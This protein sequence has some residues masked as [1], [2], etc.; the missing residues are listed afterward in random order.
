[1]IICLGILLP[2]SGQ[3]PD[4]SYNPY[5]NAGT[6]SPSPLYPTQVNGTGI[7]SFNF[8]NS[9]SDALDVYPDQQITLTITLSYGEPNAADPLNALSGDAV[10]YFD[11]TYNAGTYTAIQNAQIAAGYAGTVEIDYSVTQNSASPG[12]NGFN[13]NITPAPYQTGSNSL[14][15]DAVS[16]YT[17]TEISDHG[18]APESYGDAEHIIN[19]SLYFGSEIDGE[20]A[21]PYSEAADG[22]DT[23]NLDDEDG[24]VFPDMMRRGETVEISVLTV[25][26]GYLNAWF[27]WNGDG[28]FNDSGELVEENLQKLS[29]TGAIT[30]IIP[31][32]AIISSATYARFRISPN[33][34][35]FPT[36]TINGGEVEDYQ[37]SILC[38]IPEPVLDADKT[39]VCS[40][41]T[42]TFQASGGVNYQFRIDGV[43]VQDGVQSTF[44]TSGLTD[45]QYVD[46]QVTNG[47]GCIAISDSIVMNINPLPNVVLTSSD[48]DNAFCE[49]SEIVFD[50]QGGETYDF[51]I[52][53][54]T[55][56]SGISSEFSTS[57][58]LDGDQL[59]V[60]AYS[61]SGC[62]A[63]S[64]TL[65][66]NVFQRPTATIVISDE[67]STFCPGS[68]ITFT[69]SG[70]D[71][72]DFRIDGVS[73]QNSS[74]NL[75]T[76][77]EIIDGQAVDVI[78]TN[79][80]A[81]TDTSGQILNTV[82]PLP[83]VD[84]GEDL[85]AICQGE[86]TIPLPGSIGGSAT[87][88][89]WTT[90][91]GGTFSPNAD[92]LDAVWIPPPSFTG[93]AK[94]LLS[95]TGG[96]CGIVKDSV[97]QTVHASPELVITDPEPACAPVTVDLTAPEI[98][99]GSSA[100]LV[101][102]Y[103][104]DTTATQLLSSPTN[105]A[106]GK[107]FI[108]GTDN[109]TG[110]ASILQV[111]VTSVPTPES[112]N[113][114]I[115]DNCD[116][117][118]TLSTLA[119][120]SLLWSTGETT[121]SIVV[122]TAGDYT[123]TTTVDGCTSEATTAFANA[124]LPPD[125]PSV[126][127]STVSN[128]CP[129][130]TVDLTSLINNS[131]PVGSNLIYTTV[132][133]PQGSV[134]DDPQAV[135]AGT[136]YIFIQNAEGCYSEGT[137]VS[138]TIDACPPDLTSTLIVSPNIMHGVTDF[139][140]ILR[141]TEL[142]GV[143]SDGTITVH[144]PKDPRWILKNGFDVGMT[145]L[146]GTALNNDNWTYSE[147]DT[148]HILTSS[149][150]IT[151]GNSSTIGFIVT[152]DPGSTR[153]IYTIT[154]QILSGGGGEVRVSNNVDSERVDYFQN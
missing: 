53:G 111:V 154:A 124:L 45:E 130:T 28:D 14:N 139:S 88:A 119:A 131:I 150:V 147:N 138:V 152:F 67:D 58:L 29:G 75:F 123:V 143:N 102:T 118:T 43:P 1:M 149:A 145:E 76:T 31:E 120:G 35:E 47:D 132:D 39:S 52:N 49:G 4:G 115:T 101:Y 54:A 19:F 153:G 84:A 146:D 83:Q 7:L 122:N 46:V 106:D 27:D 80:N 137:P 33:T 135:P 30:L 95:S 50:A 36:G 68:E 38:A 148:Y 107:Y 48:G 90:L 64:D 116:G 8:G 129:G 32:D 41:D 98:T 104:L 60:T 24:V 144:I 127:S 57:N 117:T 42:V 66:Q 5:V 100:D 65:T 9:G 79:V 74:S 20:D 110:C 6:V 81:C 109:I 126:S 22:D 112:P 21:A 99:S 94:L 56:Q 71:N 82:L 128:T 105:A 63:V 17:Y 37:I 2:I 96:N 25:G 40:G 73:V 72:Y 12:L 125:A 70:G 62:V 16:S 77:T 141:I 121:S 93:V 18:D 61:D 103:W 55:V 78:V 134:V 142:N 11:W 23:D 136:Y 34:L 108:M 85:P 97:Y 13:V 86:S 26:L 113:V 59:S 10:G 151:G 114:T 133:D 92:S 69:A 91:S 51:M 15:D 44:I 89:T 87:G 140:F 3:N